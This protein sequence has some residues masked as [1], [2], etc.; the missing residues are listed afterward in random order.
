MKLKKETLHRFTESIA[1]PYQMVVIDSKGKFL[2]RVK[3][4]F[5]FIR[6]K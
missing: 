6:L 5:H 4:L 2:H 3:K 1:R